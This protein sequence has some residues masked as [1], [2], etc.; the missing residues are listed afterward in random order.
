MS[1]RRAATRAPD[2]SRKA[3]EGRVDPVNGKQKWVMALLHSVGGQFMG[4][5]R[6]YM[7]CQLSGGFKLVLFLFAVAVVLYQMNTKKET[8]TPSATVPP[9]VPT[10]KPSPDTSSESKSFTDRF[11]S[12]GIIAMNAVGFLCLWALFDTIV[13]FYNLVTKDYRPPYTY[14]RD[15]GRLWVSEKEVQ[16][17]QVYAMMMVVLVVIIGIRLFSEIPQ[18]LID[19]LSA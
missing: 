16:R 6:L 2:Y 17:G 4:L 7:G 5:D 14:C 11:S 15:E 13:V 9:A 19:N 18:W 12:A 3:Y 10:V 1:R 8:T